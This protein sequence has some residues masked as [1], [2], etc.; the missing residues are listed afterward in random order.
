VF[1]VLSYI[2]LA[3]KD[4]VENVRGLDNIKNRKNA[5]IWSIL[6]FGVSYPV[7]FQDPVLDRI[8]AYG[9]K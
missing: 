7:R 3:G 9:F 2:L 6:F 8:K 1:L 5:Q 4:Y